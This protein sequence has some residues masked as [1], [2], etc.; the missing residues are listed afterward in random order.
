MSSERRSIYD[1]H[2]SKGEKKIAQ[3]AYDKALAREMAAIRKEVEALLQRSEDPRQVWEIHR[4]LSGKDREIAEKY[5][6]RYSQLIIVFCRLV[7][8]GWLAESELS[9]LAPEKIEK[10][11]GLLAIR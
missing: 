3:A 9:G 1:L 11:R 7:R 10:I 2:W 8:E 6:Y 4:F 5:D